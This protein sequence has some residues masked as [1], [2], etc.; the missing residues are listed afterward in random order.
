MSN[1]GDELDLVD[2]NKSKE[3]H[4]HANMIL[5]LRRDSTEPV[6][7]YLA[8]SEVLVAASP[9]FASLL[10]PH[11]GEGYALRSE[12]Q[13]EIILEEDDPEAMDVLLSALHHRTTS[14]HNDVDLQL[15][16]HIAQASDK[17]RCN[18]ALSPRVFRWLREFQHPEHVA[19]QGLLLM[20]AYLFEAEDEFPAISAEAVKHL[21]LG[22]ARSWSEYDILSAFPDNIKSKQVLVYQRRPLSSD[23]TR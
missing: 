20:A 10:G 1:T 23:Q 15:L 21:P 12:Q 3:L 4:P 11:F 9:Y 2:E 7:R 5:V 19:E 18:E 6:R 14:Q 16:A 13:P 8:H 17:Y 22:F